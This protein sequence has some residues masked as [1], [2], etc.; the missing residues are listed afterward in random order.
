MRRTH[1]TL[2]THRP[3]RHRI[4]PTV[5]RLEGRAL[6]VVIT[7]TGGIA[8]GSGTSAGQTLTQSLPFAS[9]T[10]V[11]IPGYKGN[12]VS[13]DQNDDGQGIWS[14]ADLSFTPSGPLEGISFS[15]ITAGFT[16][17]AYTD[18][19]FP[20]S[21]PETAAAQAGSGASP[22]GQFI[23]VTLNPGPGDQMGDSVFVTLN[24]NGL[25]DVQPGTSA[26]YNFS[27]DVGQGTVTLL[28][29]PPAG[30]SSN[31]VESRGTEYGFQSTIGASFRISAAVF[32]SSTW[33][34]PTTGSGGYA[35]ATF[36]VDVVKDSGL[37]TSKKK[38]ADKV[39]GKELQT[40]VDTLG[41]DIT[42]LGNETNAV[43]SGVRKKNLQL[44]KEGVG[45]TVTGMTD[46]Q[47]F[48][49]L[50]SWGGLGQGYEV[51]EYGPLAKG[52]SSR[53]HIGRFNPKLPS[54]FF[55]EGFPAT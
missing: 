42:V 6:L 37:V 10:S 24:A 3:R 7:F 31:G 9:A 18:V 25:V 40:L 23:T 44:Q 12:V 16:I 5:E 19:G 49:T 8:T 50:Q 36:N 48:A 35:E 45:F 15:A 54:Q 11:V 55:K 29:G 38:I 14:D 20:K 13:N 34:D 17:A 33:A 51:I 26:G 53:I 47:V 39:L 30:A 41:W 2:T 52:R 32:A 27:Y 22:Q 28:A 1:S 4:T 46:D 21:G 43:P